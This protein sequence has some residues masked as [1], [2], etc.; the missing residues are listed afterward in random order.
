MTGQPCASYPC[1]LDPLQFRKVV[2]LGSNYSLA[3]TPSAVTSS[4]CFRRD[5]V[6]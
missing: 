2:D 1:T 3:S 6:T 5:C 4:L